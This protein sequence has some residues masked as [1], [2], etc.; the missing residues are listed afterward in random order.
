MIIKSKLLLTLIESIACLY[1]LVCR[2]LQSRE[3]KR[4]FLPFYRCIPQISVAIDLVSSIN[5]ESS[6]FSQGQKMMVLGG[7]RTWRQ[8]VEN[9]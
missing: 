4:G 7:H 3:I 6:I 9:G 5:E 1:G 8:I 2:I